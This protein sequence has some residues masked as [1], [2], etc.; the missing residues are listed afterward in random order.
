MRKTAQGTRFQYGDGAGP[1][2]LYADVAEVI[3][4]TVADF[5]NEALD[6]TLLMDEWRKSISNGLPDVG[7]VTIT[8]DWE[9]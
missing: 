6:A 5:V 3:N 9:P 2:E 8:L 4:V 7:E 1:P